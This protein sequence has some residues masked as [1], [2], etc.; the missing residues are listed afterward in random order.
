MSPTGQQHY[1]SHSLR[2]I[3]RN[4]DR[5]SGDLPGN[6][7]QYP[8]KSCGGCGSDGS[9]KTILMEVVWRVPLHLSL[10]DDVDMIN[11]LNSMNNFNRV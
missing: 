10:V 7:R 1:S 3:S 2:R 4:G 8:H 5:G 11:V 6:D 9:A